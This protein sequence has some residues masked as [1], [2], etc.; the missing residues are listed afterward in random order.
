MGFD[1]LM[2]EL[3]K[4]YMNE[5]V[6]DSFGSLI[7]ELTFLLVKEYNLF[8]NENKLK[9]MIKFI[10]IGELIIKYYIEFI[11]LYKHT[12]KLNY[13]INPLKTVNKSI[14]IK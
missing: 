4:M 14:I 2:M 6:E 13:N 12:K 7:K 5:E 1:V 10:Y 11:N 3:I 9:L 8:Y